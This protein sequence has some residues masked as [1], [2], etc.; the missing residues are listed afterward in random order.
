MTK[1]LCIIGIIIGPILCVFENEI[2]LMIGLVVLLGSI[3][4]LITN[5]LAETQG[6]I[7][8]ISGIFISLSLIAFMLLNL[9]GKVSFLPYS[10]ALYTTLFWIAFPLMIAGGGTATVKLIII[11]LR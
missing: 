1:L 9:I 6:I 11:F 10:E 3:G 4:I 7:G 8:A 2:L 5:I